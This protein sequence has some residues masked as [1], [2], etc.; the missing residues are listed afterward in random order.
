[1]AA[2]GPSFTESCA[3]TNAPPDELATGIDLAPRPNGVRPAQAVARQSRSTRIVL[4]SGNPPDRRGVDPGWRY[5]A[6][7]FPIED[8][9]EC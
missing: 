7:P 8:L 1:M 9:V 4:I 5:L 6:K 2:S 3:A